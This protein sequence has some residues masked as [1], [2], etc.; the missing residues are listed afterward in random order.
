MLLISVKYR[1]W[2][3]TV[4]FRCIGR[5]SDQNEWDTRAL[6]DPKNERQRSVND[7][8]SCVLGNLGGDRLDTVIYNVLA[9]IIA[10]RESEMLPTP[11]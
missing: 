4:D 1:H 5:L 9:A 8:W 2:C 6:P 7:C 11:S 3:I 10:K